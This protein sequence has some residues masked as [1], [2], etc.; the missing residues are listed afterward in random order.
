MALLPEPLLCSLSHCSL[1]SF[2]ISSKA[3]TLWQLSESE[4]VQGLCSCVL[5]SS[6]H[7]TGSAQAVAGGTHSP[8]PDLS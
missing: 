5:L 2:L 4:S 6:S 7:S 8:L 3:V 1:W